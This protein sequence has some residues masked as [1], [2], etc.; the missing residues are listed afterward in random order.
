MKDHPAQYSSVALKV[1]HDF[2]IAIHNESSVNAVLWHLTEHCIEQI[3]LEDCV[4]YMVDEMRNLMVQRAAYG[5]KN[6]RPRI[7]DNPLEIPIGRGIV[8]S[9]ALNGKS[10]LIKDVREDARYIVDDA[11]RLSELAVPILV[12][13]T[14][15]GVIDSE[16]TE[17]EFFNEFHQITLEL[18]AAIAATKIAQVRSERERNEHAIFHRLNPNPVFR[19]SHDGHLLDANDASR[20]LLQDL[21]VS[22]DPQKH[23]FLQEV[24]TQAVKT[25]QRSEVHITAG[26]RTF[27]T[28]IVP[29]SSQDYVN[30]YATDV[31]DLELAKQVAQKANKAKAEFLSVV[32]HE[33]RTPLN[34]LKGLTRL[35]ELSELNEKQKEYVSTLQFSTEQLMLLINDV[36]DFERLEV[37]KLRLEN[38]AF[39]LEVVFNQAF[40]V[41]R[42]EARDKG[43][44]FRVAINLDRTSVV[45]DQMRLTQIINNLVSNAV[46][47]TDEGFVQV[48]ATL[49][50]ID[51]TKGELLFVVEDSGRGIPKEELGHI[52]TPFYQANRDVYK[53]AGGTG[54]GLSITK[55][56]LALMDGDIA[57]SS[58]VGDGT[59]F[60]VRIPLQ[61][62][63][64]DFAKAK[65]ADETV[66]DKE[67]LHKLKVLV[68]DD[69]EINMKVAESFLKMWN[70]TVLKAADGEQAIDT[71]R[72]TSPEAIIMDIQMPVMD[73]FEATRILRSSGKADDIPIIGLTADVSEETQERARLAG[74]NCLLTKPFNPTELYGMLDG[75]RKGV[76]P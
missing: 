60:E 66:Q 55:R 16:H 12:K 5:P 52:F 59:K 58:S 30:L 34:A 21:L 41:F 36:L 6:V 46:K 26:K 19:V 67:N 73:G 65:D 23:G 3:G 14:V 15:I 74:M 17:A 2:A 39:D 13:G 22:D 70:A 1:V 8:G 71:Y 69:N 57:V 44:D 29:V 38:T 31:T 62:P 54:L 45:S 20:E 7:V 75:I 35:L 50:T 27:K 68:V 47:Y 33:I 40:S 64:S 24:I 72:E 25:G 63:D 49:N 4:V 76:M 48:K 32:S 28:S 61:Y 18:L 42:A 11:Q 10:E 9:V 51:D 56:I 53:P 37:N 43:V